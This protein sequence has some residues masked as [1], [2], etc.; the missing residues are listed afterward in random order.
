MEDDVYMEENLRWKKILD[1][2]QPSM[3]LQLSSKVNLQKRTT[4]LCISK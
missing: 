3:E 2:S 1:G 4:G